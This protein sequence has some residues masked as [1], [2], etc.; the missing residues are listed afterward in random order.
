MQTRTEAPERSGGR[1]CLFR[2]LWGL[3]LIVSLGACSPALNWRDVR[4]DNA[5]WTGWLPCK[6]DIAER[7]VNLG[8]Q[9][10]KLRLMGCE[11]DGMDFTLAQLPLPATLSAV[12][13]QQAWKQ[14]SL[15]S[16][17][18][19]ADVPSQDWVLAGASSVMTPQRVVAQGGQGLTARWAWFAYDGQLFQVAVYARVARAGQA[20]QAMD[21]LVSGL[22]LP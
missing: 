8:D 16:L 19:S 15:S 3:V 10:A 14:A 9:V 22:R 7:P 1:L 17:Q 6:P 12:Q 11:A 18:A 4:F 2:C 13:A 20:D 5:R 21:T